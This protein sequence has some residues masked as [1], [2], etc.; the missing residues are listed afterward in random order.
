MRQPSRGGKGSQKQATESRQ[1]PLLLLGVPSYTTLT[2]AKGLGQFHVSFLADGSD[3]VS[4][5]G[6]HLKNTS[7]PELLIDPCGGNDSKK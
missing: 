6:T 2:C 1:P 4:P 5:Y 7:R 3:S